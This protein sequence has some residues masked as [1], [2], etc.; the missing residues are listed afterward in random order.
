MEKQWGAFCDV[1]GINPRNRII[2]FFLEMREAD[3]TIGDI[4]KET[5]LNRATAYNTTEELLKEA[6]LIPS[7]KVSGGQ[8]YKLNT[9]KE[10]VKV[11]IKT[12]NIILKEIV[13]EYKDHTKRKKLYA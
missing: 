4:A 7:R 9:Q 2:E 1:F 5:G 3:F 12:F 11:F 8:L 6:Y 10:E 13:H